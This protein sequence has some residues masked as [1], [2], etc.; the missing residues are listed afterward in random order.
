MSR[1]AHAT[2]RDT[3]LLLARS[4]GRPQVASPEWDP[5][6]REDRRSRRVGVGLAH[7]RVAVAVSRLLLQL[8]L[9]RRT[10]RLGD[11]SRVACVV[12]VGACG[13][14]AVAD[15]RDDM[16][17]APG[18]PRFGAGGMDSEADAGDR[19]TRTHRP[20]FPGRAYSAAMPGWPPC[21]RPCYK[22]SFHGS[23]RFGCTR[24]RLAPPKCLLEAQKASALPRRFRSYDFGLLFLCT[25]R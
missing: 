3:G 11:C 21:R 23:S 5:R 4:D 10:L 15:E 1:T 12:R 17:P 8:Q 7:T 20:G 9:A 22:P 2:R 18:D 25:V 24:R 13:A 6:G 16:P 19:R 14:S